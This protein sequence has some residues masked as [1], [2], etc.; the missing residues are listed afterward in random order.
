[1]ES[2]S[3]QEREVRAARNQSIFRAVNEKLEAVNEAF[4]RVTETFTIACECADI[5]C[6]EMLDIRP[7]DYDAVR[8]EP[9]HFV[10]LRG[11]IYLDVER[12]IRE[13]DGYAVVEKTAAAG[14]AAEILA[15]PGGA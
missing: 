2:S 8:A 11:H 10:V 3:Q 15:E 6:V 13:S 12:V 1:M 9:R 5:N 14:E 4:E 7:E